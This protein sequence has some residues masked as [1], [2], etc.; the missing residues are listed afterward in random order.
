MLKEVASRFTELCRLNNKDGTGHIEMI[1]GFTFF[2]ATVL[3]LFVLIRVDGDTLEAPNS[4]LKNLEENFQD[5]TETEVTSFFVKLDSAPAPG[6]IS[7][8]LSQ[9]KFNSSLKAATFVDSELKGDNLLLSNLGVS[10]FMVSLS[11]DLNQTDISPCT[12]FTDFTLGPLTNEKYVSIEKIHSLEAEYNSDYDSLKARMG[13]GALYDFS[14]ESVSGVI[15][16]SRPIS[17]SVNVYA[18][19]NKLSTMDKTGQKEI[20]EVIFKIW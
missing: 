10:E 19:K 14:I 11:A 15:D 16:L 4:L 13:I 8:D 12:A 7:L 3:F 6:C 17:P 20:I 9:Y 1:M 2:I 18:S 5:I